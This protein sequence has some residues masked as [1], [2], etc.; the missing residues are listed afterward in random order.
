MRRAT[1][2]ELIVKANHCVDLRV[3]EFV[4]SYHVLLGEPNRAGF[5][6]SED[7]NKVK[8]RSVKL[9]GPFVPYIAR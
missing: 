2:A 9:G 8:N 3:C 7:L 6:F 4:Y 1:R 5:K